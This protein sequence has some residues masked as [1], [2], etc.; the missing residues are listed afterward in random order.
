M[1][2]RTAKGV[3]RM[4]DFDAGVIE[5]DGI[6]MSLEWYERELGPLLDEFEKQGKDVFAYLR[7]GLK[8]KAPESVRGSHGVDPEA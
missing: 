1:T 8:E 6:S 4:I 2:D 7:E 5:V 3:T